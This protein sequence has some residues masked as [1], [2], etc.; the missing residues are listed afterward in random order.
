[1]RFASRPRE[2]QPD[3][4]ADRRPPD[5]DGLT[6]A[7]RDGVDE[8]PAARPSV[9]SAVLRRHRHA[10]RRRW[11]LV[12]HGDADRPA[13]AGAAVLDRFCARTRTAT[14]WSR[15]SSGS[16]SPSTTRRSWPSRCGRGRRR[17][18]A[19]L[20]FRT[21][22]DDWTTAGP[23]HALR[24]ETGASDGLKPYVHVRAGLW[25][26]LTRRALL[27][28][29]RARRDARERGGR[30][31][32]GVSLRR[33]L[34]PDGKGQRAR[35]HDMT[36]PQRSPETAAAH[37]RAQ[38]FEGCRA[39]RVGAKRVGAGRV[40]NP[41]RA[42]AFLAIAVAITLAVL[43]GSIVGDRPARRSRA[44]SASAPPEA[45]WVTNAYQLAVT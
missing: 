40:P 14:C 43:D 6:Q 2:E 33:R 35:R 29:R 17:R 31:S 22:V 4:R 24:F 10:D 36:R 23:E 3:G 37:E 28:P 11:H 18:A 45:I 19:S 13:G 32:F 39:K 44:S 12:L 25:A 41:Q 1:M 30:R 5:L 27:R 16:A 42:L 21:N 26:R 9:E 8:G 7:A 20:A 34:L 38:R 15:R